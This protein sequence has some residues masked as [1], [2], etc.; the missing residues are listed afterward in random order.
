MS[1]DQVPHDGELSLRVRR[2][3]AKPEQQFVGPS[4]LSFLRHSFSTVGEPVVC[5]R[6]SAAA[7][8]QL[9]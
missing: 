5:R 1:F 8:A 3:F 9:L 2:L 4:T 6:T 7:S